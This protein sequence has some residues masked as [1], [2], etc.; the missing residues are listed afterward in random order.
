MK[1]EKDGPP[2]TPATPGTR[3]DA[4]RARAIAER[5]AAG[6]RHTAIAERYGISVETVGAI[7]SGK[8]WASAI[9]DDLRARMGQAS[10]AGVLDETGAR[11]IMAALLVGRSGRSIA[12]GFGVSPSM[13]SAIAH[14]RAWASLDPELP[15]RLAQGPR[16]GKALSESQVAGIKRAL[17]EGRSTRKIAKEY[18]VSASTVQAISRGKTWA[19]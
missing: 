5:I 12:T 13:V 4:D 19:E 10:S 16:K 1:P 9:D 17:R 2:A 7:K 8:R 11:G 6:E 18:G 15:A 14:G 3:L